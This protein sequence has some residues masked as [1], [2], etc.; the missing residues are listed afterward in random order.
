MKMLDYHLTP[1][2]VRDKMNLNKTQ[3]T[4]TA[5]IFLGLVKCKLNSLSRLMTMTGFFSLDEVEVV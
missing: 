1:A 4:V 3:S 5:F 2:I